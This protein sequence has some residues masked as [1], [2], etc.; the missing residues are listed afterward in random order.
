MTT[1]SPGVGAEHPT[2][3]LRSHDIVDEVTQEQGILDVIVVS[4]A[5]PV[6]EGRAKHIYITGKESSL[7]IWPKHTD[8][9]AAL[10]TGPLRI[11][12]ID[13]NVE[14]F[15]VSGGFLKVGGSKVTILID[16]AVRADEVEQAQVSKELDEVKAKLKSPKSDEEFEALRA[17]RDW[18]QAKLALL[19]G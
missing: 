15:A 19:A 12:T 13:G 1:E 10:G 2:G 9:V 3:S 17:K 14:R 16:K 4:P 11:A 5:R 18:C 7:G 6:Y 8:I